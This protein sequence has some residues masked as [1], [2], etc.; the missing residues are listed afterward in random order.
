MNCFGYILWA[1]LTMPIK[2]VPCCFKATAVATE[3]NAL[4]AITICALPCHGADMRKF[5]AVPEPYPVHKVCCTGAK[6]L[7]KAQDASLLNSYSL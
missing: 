6:L 7:H 4:S 3:L 2:Y 5:T 1:V